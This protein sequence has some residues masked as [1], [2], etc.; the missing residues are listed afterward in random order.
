MQSCFLTALS[1]H[2]FVYDFPI[3]QY[4]EHLSIRMG[5]I[6]PF[7]VII[8]F[9][10]S[11]AEFTREKNQ[12]RA[13]IKLVFLNLLMF[14]FL[15]FQIF[16]ILSYI[17]EGFADLIKFHTSIRY[18]LKYLSSSG[19]KSKNRVTVSALRELTKASS[20]KRRNF[21]ENPESCR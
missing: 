9:T 1:S 15:L 12:D 10:K 2:L 5:H 8:S 20:F 7:V 21:F 17:R 6:K 13:T 3:S 19:L 14:L 16:Q 4:L 11:I 18:F